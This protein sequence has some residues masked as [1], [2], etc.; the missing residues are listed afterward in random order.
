MEKV[1]PFNFTNLKILTNNRVFLCFI[2]S[3][4]YSISI[5]AAEIDISGLK[6]QCNNLTPQQRQMAK[7]AGYDVDSAC[8][9][10]QSVSKN[11]LS[12]SASIPQ[13]I[14]P[15]GSVITTSDR[16][17]IGETTAIVDAPASKQRLVDKKT[18]LV[19]YG[20]EL[21]A[22]VP[23]TFAPTTNILV[24]S[25][26]IVGPGDSF[27]IQLLGKVNQSYQ[28]NV[29]RDGSINFPEL[30]PMAV[31]SLKYS[32]AKDLIQHKVS[33][34]M[35]GVRA[36]ISLADL[37][38]IR[39]FILGEAFKPGSYTVS[40]LSTMTNAIFVSGGITEIGSLRNIQLKRQ[41]KVITTL[42]LY[43]L[44][45]N[46]DTSNDSRLLPGDVI[47]I[48]TVGLTAG[49]KGEIKRP[50]IYEL[51]G[52][53]TL[54]ELIKLAGG[55]SS[56]AFPNSS[57]I[58][59]NS[60]N[61]FTTVID[62]DL[63]KKKAN[64][65]PVL[66]GD[67]VN[68]ST[69]LDTYEG[70]V[71]LTGAFHR[72]R[73]VKWENGLK[74]SSL[75]S[76][77]KEFVDNADLKIGLIIRQD[78]PL[79]NYSVL[80]FDIQALL[81]GDPSS[82]IELNP[83]D[84]ILTFKSS[85]SR[86]LVLKSVN[87][88]L[89]QQ[90]M[91]GRL[92]H[93]VNVNGNVRYPGKYPYTHNMKVRDL[94]LLAGGLLEASYLGNAQITRQDLSNAEVASIEHLNVNLFN[95]LTDKSETYLSPKDKLAIYTTPD[96]RENHSVTLKGEV[97]FPGRYE[98]KRGETLSQVII[99]AGGFTNMAHISASVFTRKD[100]KRLEEK[101]LKALQEQMK[102][103][104][105]A[106][107]LEDAAGGKV[108]AIKDSE[109]LLNALSNTEAIGRL[110]I[111]M[112]G[113]M[114]GSTDDIQLKDGDFLT[115]PGY[116]QEISVLGEVQHATSHIFTKGWTL[117]DYLENSGGLTPRGDDDRI[118]VVKANGSVFL[119]SQTGWLG[120]QNE[121]LSPGDT[122]VVPLDT[123]RIKTLTL[124]TNV[125]QI[126]YQMALGAAAVNSL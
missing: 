96:Y 88:K 4:V 41:G 1:M 29:N 120:H 98:F 63:S 109:D 42:D 122:I 7:A 27:Q 71:T 15:R 99:R 28:L 76:S 107:Q 70:V 25:D 16:G 44:L 46:G 30:G 47:Y 17:V 119:P 117:D 14:L 101:Q 11:D 97:K 112:E 125:S 10:L 80:H 102:A 91:K 6:S 77:A 31:S 83:M 38:S 114:N 18:K 66:N 86:L 43:A 68:I 113:I 20:Y 23:T 32:E 124:W 103:D 87:N 52:K 126:I 51:K 106:S 8:S 100:L 59:R 73:K 115:I 90:D 13:T 92:A 95:E 89:Q 9:S 78:M 81:N 65:E 82:D 121:M 36:V 84:E 74:L 21:F 123:D 67:I 94:V 39:I 35:I 40:S 85:D 56:N 45:Q 58:S 37:R 5:N 61:G 22:G 34:Q 26:Y 62:I 12:S 3:L 93:I 105:A 24:P 72:E 49:I 60:K 64:S 33:Q 53:Q 50:A 111:K 69:K 110:V 104:I 57:S 79:R 55:Y 118:Y 48:P 75:I 116:R 19:K 108:G 54:A 2:I